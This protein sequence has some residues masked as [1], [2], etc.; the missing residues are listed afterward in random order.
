VAARN[1][2]LRNLVPNVQNGDG[3]GYKEG[4]LTVGTLDGAAAQRAWREPMFHVEHRWFRRS[5]AEPA[6]DTR[7]FGRLVKSE[8]VLLPIALRA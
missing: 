8:A 2:A 7:G 4:G 5:A 6:G 1:D 3:R